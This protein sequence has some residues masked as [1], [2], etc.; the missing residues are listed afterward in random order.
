MDRG[1]VHIDA[2]R[3]AL[4]HIREETMRELRGEAAA[5]VP[6]KAAVE[7]AP[8]GQIAAV[9]GEAVDIDGGRQDHRARQG[10]RHQMV[11]QALDDGGTHDLVAMDARAHEDTRPALRPVQHFERERGI[12]ARDLLADRNGEDFRRARCDAAIVDGEGGGRVVGT[13]AAF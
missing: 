8:I 5:L 12:E 9:R 11:E 13:H 7:I 2:E 1:G 3:A 6:W 10:F 4:D